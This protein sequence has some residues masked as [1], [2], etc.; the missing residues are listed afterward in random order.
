M[1]KDNEP[2]YCLWED[3]PPPTGDTDM[4]ETDIGC[5]CYECVQDRSQR[6]AKKQKINNL[7]S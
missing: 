5:Q 3:W 4:C 1:E 7:R 6:L 2:V